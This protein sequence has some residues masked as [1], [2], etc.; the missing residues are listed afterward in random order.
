MQCQLCKYIFTIAQWINKL[1]FFS[2]GK[3]DLT[4]LGTCIKNNGKSLAFERRS[5]RIVGAEIF[6]FK[7]KVNSL[8]NQI[9]NAL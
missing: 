8:K 2:N 1:F 9:S 3:I 7:R 4:N 6:I 5:D